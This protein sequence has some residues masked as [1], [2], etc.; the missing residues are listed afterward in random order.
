MTDSGRSISGSYGGLQAV[1]RN[2]PPDSVASEY[3]S[4][5]FNIVLEH[6]V[7]IIN[8]IKIRPLKIRLFKKMCEDMGAEYTSLLYYCLSRWLSLIGAL[9]PRFQLRQ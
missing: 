7:N 2:K 1:I 8:Y 3:M 6:V 4:P 9:S 5:T